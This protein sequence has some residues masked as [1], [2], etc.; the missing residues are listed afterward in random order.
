[1]RSSRSA[2]ASTTCSSRCSLPE[3]LSRLFAVRCVEFDGQAG[4]SVTKR[5]EVRAAAAVAVE[6]CPQL[7]RGRVDGYPRLAEADADALFFGA[8]PSRKR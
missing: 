6:W 7:L 8:P 4:A 3:Q 2:A 5:L 1:M